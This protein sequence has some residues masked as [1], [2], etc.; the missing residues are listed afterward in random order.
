MKDVR[1]LVL[2]TND[3]KLSREIHPRISSGKRCYY[4]LSSVLRSIN[5]NRKL[6][7]AIYK[8]ILRPI[9]IYDSKALTVRE[10]NRHNNMK[11]RYCK[12]FCDARMDRVR[13]RMRT[14]EDLERIFGELD[15][16]TVIK[17]NRIRWA[18][19]V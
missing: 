6:I 3:N 11:D 7:I 15:V 8:T 17:R 13:C 19:H 9:I 5:I 12:R 16:V 18:V 10:E 14:D 4:A 2:I 1:I